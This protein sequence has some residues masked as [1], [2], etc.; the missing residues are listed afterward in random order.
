V[1]LRSGDRYRVLVIDEDAD[2]RRR[3]ATELGAHPYFDLVGEAA[4]SVAGVR[5]ATELEPDLVVFDPATSGGSGVEAVRELI[6][7]APG[8]GVVVYSDDGAGDDAIR[9]AGAH[10]CVRKAGTDSGLMDALR[11]TAARR[12]GRS[13]PRVLS[14]AE[15]LRRLVFE[16]M[17][18]G[19]VVQDRAGRIAFANAAAQR[20][21]ERTSSELLG[22]TS[23]DPHWGAVHPDGTAWPGKQHPAS[24]ALRTQQPVRN[25][26]MGVRRGSDEQCWLSVSAT[27][28]RNESGST[29]GVVVTFVDV[30]EKHEAGLARLQSD[31][32]FRSAVDSMLDG[33]MILRAVRDDDQVTDFVYEFVNAGVETNAGY[34]PEELLGKRLLDV[35]P[36]LATNGAFARYADAVETGVPIVMEVPW[37]SGPRVQG[38]FEVRGVRVGD[39]LALTFRN[40]TERKLS[41]AAALRRPA[42]EV[43]GGPEP[44]AEPVDLRLTDRELE[45]LQ[46]LGE[47]VS[48]RA[49]SERLFISLNT[50]RNHVQRVIGKLGAHSRLEAVAIARR[51]GLLPGDL[52]RV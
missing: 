25:V 44:G 18:E 21:L 29:I 7:T 49:I 12:S 5:L 35:V 11:S 28:M 48:T 22:G 50:S 43:P 15:E 2:A 19:V 8:V 39:G 4:D 47:G 33:F 13:D 1:G 38:A 17:S 32:R 36:D 14:D 27:P 20:I 34:R 37:A 10:E 3:V 26:L 46:L 41:E 9:A 24:E 40:I 31:E 45:V 30:T 51:S 6:G 52:R 42:V 16:S 23:M